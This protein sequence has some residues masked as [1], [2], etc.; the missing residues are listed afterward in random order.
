MFFLFPD[1]HI[2]R[3]G[4]FGR[5]KFGQNSPDYKLTSHNNHQQ[6]DGPHQNLVDLRLQESVVINPGHLLNGSH[7]GRSARIQADEHGRN[8]GI[9][10]RVG[11]AEQI[12]AGD[13]NEHTRQQA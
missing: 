10:L 12:K 9:M 1:F 7:I 11:T 5:F 6:I 3:I 8:A 4:L 13:R 2:F